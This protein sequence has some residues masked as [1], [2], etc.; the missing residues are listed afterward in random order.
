LIP[1]GFQV[2]SLTNSTALGVNS[3]IRACTVLD[4]SV[5]TNAVRYREDAT[6][7][8][9]NTGVLIAANTFYRWFG[10]NGTSN[11][12]FQRSTATAKVSIMGYKHPADGR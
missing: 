7:P 8:T 9:K 12:K 4:I 3:T 6:A 2:L 10:Y 11:L 1:V 5:E